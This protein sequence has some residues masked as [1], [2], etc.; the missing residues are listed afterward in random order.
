MCIRDRANYLAEDCLLACS[1]CNADADFMGALLCGVGNDAVDSDDGEDERKQT[2]RT[3]EYR[4][5]ALEDAS[6]AHT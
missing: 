4:C 1:E 2:K 5:D 3:G 6:H